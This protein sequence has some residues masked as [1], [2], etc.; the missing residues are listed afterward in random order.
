MVHASP[1]TH[2]TPAQ[3]A[4]AQPARR[5]R[6]VTSAPRRPHIATNRQ[7]TNVREQPGSPDPPHPAPASALARAVAALRNLPLPRCR[8]PLPTSPATTHPPPLRIIHIVAARVTCSATACGVRACH[9]PPL[10]KLHA[11]CPVHYREMLPQRTFAPS[12]SDAVTRKSAVPTKRMHTTPGTWLARGATKPRDGTHAALSRPPARGLR[13]GEG[14]GERRRGRTVRP[15]SSAPY[16]PRRR[17]LCH[18][19]CCYPLASS[20]RR[21]WWWAASS[22]AWP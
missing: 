2:A 22:R 21:D 6:V 7:C 15:A 16:R 4:A 3:A 1:R 18:R 8:P 19:C 17:R 10:Y 11:S 13:E 9:Q 20:A 14:R 12:W 5:L